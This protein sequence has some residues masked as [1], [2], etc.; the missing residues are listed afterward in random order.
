M[1][2]ININVFV[3]GAGKGIGE[4]TVFSLLENGA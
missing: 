4:E 1:Q 3:T 2:K